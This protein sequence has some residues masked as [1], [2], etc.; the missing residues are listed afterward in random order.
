MMQIKNKTRFCRTCQLTLIPLFALL[1]SA[2]FNLQNAG[3]Q[4]SQVNDKPAF[5]RLRITESDLG[6]EKPSDDLCSINAIRRFLAGQ[7]RYPEAAAEAGQSGTVELYARIN[8]QGLINEILELQPVRDYIDVS[9]IVI[10]ATAPAGKEITVSSRHSSL[11]A[12]SRRVLMALPKC[13]IQEI[14]GQTLKFTFKFV[15]K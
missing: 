2:F 9:E 12:E 7:I 15:L 8:N 14:F 5:H 4:D 13:D 3:A 11:M 1:F 10:S 6:K